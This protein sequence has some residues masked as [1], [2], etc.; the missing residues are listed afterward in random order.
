MKVDNVPYSDID[1]EAQIAALLHIANNL[2]FGYK[3]NK[4]TGAI[5]DLLLEQV[6]YID[7][8]SKNL[9]RVATMAGDG[10]NAKLSRV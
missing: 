1:I 4:S 6:K 5:S 3:E 2:G 10:P 8:I 9:K 7:K